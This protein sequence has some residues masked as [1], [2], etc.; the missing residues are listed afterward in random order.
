MISVSRIE[1]WK[2]SKLHLG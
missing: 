2:H 1:C